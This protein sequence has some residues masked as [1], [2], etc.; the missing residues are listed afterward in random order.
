MFR[1]L[2]ICVA[3]L[4]LYFGF[5]LIQ[6]FD[7]KILVS[8]YSYNIEASF[9]FSIILGVLLITSCFIVI[10]FSILIIDLPLKINNI[11]SKRKINHDRYALILAFAE[12]IMSNKT[13]AASIARK[14]LSSKNLKE[15]QEFYNLILAETEEDVDIK[16]SYFQKLTKSKEFAFYS[17]KSL[18][19]LYYN[20]S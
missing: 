2:L 11:L 13:K 12:Y 10:R 15:L 19:K 8:L 17:A 7:S 9:F 20:K 3:L 6:N 18:A 16:I 5:T 1:L 4:L 14:S